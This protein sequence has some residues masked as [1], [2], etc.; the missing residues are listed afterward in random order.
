MSKSTHVKSILYIFPLHEELKKGETHANVESSKT[1]IE[2]DKTKIESETKPLGYILKLSIINE[3]PILEIIPVFKIKKNEKS[4]GIYTRKNKSLI[5]IYIYPIKNMNLLKYIKKFNVKDEYQIDYI[6]QVKKSIFKKQSSSRDSNITHLFSSGGGKDNKL[7]LDVIL[8]NEHFFTYKDDSKYGPIFTIRVTFT[9]NKVEITNTKY[10]TE[11]NNKNKDT[12]LPNYIND[13]HVNHYIIPIVYNNT[14]AFKYFTTIV[15]PVQNYSSLT[16]DDSREKIVKIA[17][18]LK[19]LLNKS[20]INNNMSLVD[21]NTFE[22]NCLIMFFKNISSIVYNAYINLGFSQSKINYID[23]KIDSYTTHETKL[24]FLTESTLVLMNILEIFDI[25]LSYN[26]VKNILTYDIYIK[27]F[28]D[29]NLHLFDLF[30]C[31]KK[32]D[33]QIIK[34]FGSMRVNTQHTSEVY[35]SNIISRLED[36]TIT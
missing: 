28:N 10:N 16:I 18:D 1:K 34:T 32:T 9:K 19:G 4:Y 17:K 27:L 6:Y 15:K 14:S 30:D 31:L 7:T 22:S 23:K 25:Q 29:I 3:L 12:I 26:Q 24:E 11:Y 2:S 35:L 5:G 20:I 21:D 33:S 13:T 36:S 8:V